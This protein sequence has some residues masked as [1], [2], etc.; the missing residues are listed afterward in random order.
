MSTNPQTTPHFPKMSS[1]PQCRK[2]VVISVHTNTHTSSVGAVSL[3]C[4][5]ATQ[6]ISCEPRGQ[7]IYSSQRPFHTTEQCV[8]VSVCVCVWGRVGGNRNRWNT[9][10][11]KSAFVERYE[12]LDIWW[13]IKGDRKDTS[14]WERDAGNWGSRIEEGHEERQKGWFCRRVRSSPTPGLQTVRSVSDIN[15][16]FIWTHALI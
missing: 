4:P 14:K 3:I 15:H 9:F 10:W 12:G 11:I 16:V 8:Y 6:W 5:A 7:A 2:C 13:D 1:L